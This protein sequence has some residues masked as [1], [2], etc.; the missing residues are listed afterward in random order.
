VF[1]LIFTLPEVINS[2]KPFASGPTI[3]DSLLTVIIIASIAYTLGSV[4]SSNSMIKERAPLLYRWTDKIVFLLISG[5][6]IGYLGTYP[7][8]IVLWLIPVILFGLGYGLLLRIVGIRPKVSKV[9]F[10]KTGALS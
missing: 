6:V 5:T 3:A 4:I 1:A 2:M 8:D 9:L 7:L 10:R